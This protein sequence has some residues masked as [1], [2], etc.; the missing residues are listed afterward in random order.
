VINAPNI[1]KEKPSIRPTDIEM[2]TG[3]S[4]NE[5]IYKFV[6]DVVSVMSR[7]IVDMYER[8]IEAGMHKRKIKMFLTDI[9]G[10]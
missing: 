3:S 9:A 4:V 5:I 7:I 1:G 10:L 2:I 8:M 6:F